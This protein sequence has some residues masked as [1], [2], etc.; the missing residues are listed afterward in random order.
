MSKPIALEPVLHPK[1]GQ[2]YH[3]SWSK[4]PH[5]NWILMQINPDGTCILGSKLSR[6]QTEVSTLRT[7]ARVHTREKS[8]QLEFTF[9]NQLQLR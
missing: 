9:L 2:R 4:N 3:T 1:I 5:M 8:R 6:F 7:K